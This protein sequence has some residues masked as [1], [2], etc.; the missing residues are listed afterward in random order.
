MYSETFSW[1]HIQRLH[2]FIMKTCMLTYTHAHTPAIAPTLHLPSWITRE[3]QHSSNQGHNH[4]LSDTQSLPPHWPRAL[5]TLQG[6]QSH[7][8]AQ[9]VEA[10]VYSGL[11]PGLLVSTGWSRFPSSSSPGCHQLNVCQWHRSIA[12]QDRRS[13]SRERRRMNQTTGPSVLCP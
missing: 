1:P 9:P 10:C 11:W 7:K 13:G 8:S 6:S 12:R 2:I 5:M 4:T 3:G